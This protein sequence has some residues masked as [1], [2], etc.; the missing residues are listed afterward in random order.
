[1]NEKRNVLAHNIAAV[2]E[3]KGITQTFLANKLGKT[4]QWLSN[5]E[6]GRRRVAAIELY[7]IAEA[8]N[9]SVEVFYADDLNA[10]F[11]TED[12]GQAPAK[13]AV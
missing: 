1:M 12:D 8:L 13:E 2:R 7:A 10:T 11:K 9:T 6:A 4:P 3:S 5:I